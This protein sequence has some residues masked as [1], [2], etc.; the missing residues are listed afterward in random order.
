[1]QPPRHLVSAGADQQALDVEE[2]ILVG[3]VVLEI[4]QVLLRDGVERAANRMRIRRRDD[5]A[6][7]QHHQVRIVNRHERRK[8]ERLGVLEVFVEYAGDVLGCESHEASIAR[9]YLKYAFGTAPTT[10]SSVAICSPA[11]HVKC[12][13]ILVSIA[14]IRAS[15]RSN[16]LSN[17][18]S[19]ESNR[20]STCSNRLSTCSKRLS[21]CS[22]RISICSNRLSTCSNRISIC[23]NRLSTCSNRLSTCSNRLSTCSKRRCMSPRSPAMSSRKPSVA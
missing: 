5:A 3:A 15:T 9:N 14:T 22:N 10:A 17:L 23:S 18:A 2:E 1:M 8:K 12:R 7:S 4:A 19:T 13:S 21:T 6:I 11:S 16:L 20:F